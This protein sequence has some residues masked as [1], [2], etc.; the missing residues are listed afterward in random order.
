MTK[1]LAKFRKN[2]EG[3]ALIEYSILIGLITAAVIALIALVGPW[4]TAQWTT[5]TTALGL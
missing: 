3:A 5:L 1:L 4:I 2:E